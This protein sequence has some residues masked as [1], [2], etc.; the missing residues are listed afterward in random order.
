MM[1]GFEVHGEFL[2]QGKYVLLQKCCTGCG[3]DNVIHIK[4]PIYHICAASEDK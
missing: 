2:L 3:E 4:Q 1:E